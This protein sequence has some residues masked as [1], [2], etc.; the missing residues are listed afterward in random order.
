MP[1]LLTAIVGALAGVIAAQFMRL[2]A[3]VFVA[4]AIGIIGAVIGGVVLRF[5]LLFVLG[6]SSLLGLFIGALLGALALIW[7]Y[8]ALFRGDK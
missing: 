8:R 1:I 2:N 6:A 5:L 3:N 7:A 4:M